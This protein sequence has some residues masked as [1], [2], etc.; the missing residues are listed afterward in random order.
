MG[1]KDG[2]IVAERFEKIDKDRLIGIER[3][4]GDIPLIAHPAPECGKER[5]DICRRWWWC[6]SGEGFSILKIADEQPT[7]AGVCADALLP[8]EGRRGCSEPVHNIVEHKTCRM[9]PVG[10]TCEQ[11]HLLFNGA[12]RVSMVLKP[13]LEAIDIWFRKVQ[14]TLYA[15]P[16]PAFLLRHDCPLCLL[17]GHSMRRLTSGGSRG[18][19]TNPP[20]HRRSVPLWIQYASR[21]ALS[22]PLP[23]ALRD[24]RGHGCGRTFSFARMSDDALVHRRAIW[25][26]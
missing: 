11:P 17:G 13:V 19:G 8:L 1:G 4:V 21:S 15:V 9:H 18:A 5:P 3:R 26:R 2:R 6:R 16:M 10:P 25:C 24:C 7:C 23:S 14:P 22:R 20:I 12:R